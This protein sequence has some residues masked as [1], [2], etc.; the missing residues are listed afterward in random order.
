MIVRER[1]NEFIMIEQHNHALTSGDIMS[2]WKDSLFHG[3]A[4]RKS[5]ETAIYMHDYGWKEFDKQPFWNDQT[6]APYTFSDF[7]T[8]P[9]IILY[10]HGIN[11]VEK[12]DMYAALLCSEHYTRF[13]LNH[14][15]VEAQ[16]FVTEEKK[17]Q[18][19]ILKSLGNIDK[20][21]F[22][23]HYGL[24]QLGDNLSLFLCLN[25]PGV[26]KEKE[27][28]FFKHGIPLASSIEGVNQST[29]G[30]EWIDNQTV[31]VHEFPFDQAFTVAFN[32]K[33]VSKAS[34]KELG[35]I[36]AYEEASSEKVTVQLVPE[37]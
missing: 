6:Q 12:K 11:E 19:R 10:A 2:H 18:K 22:R 7:P 3:K 16:S 5:V 24:L 36:N 32:Q 34:I 29:L 28:H 30:V 27:H 1:E 35:L 8:Y 13:L 21:L 33:K 14:T 17:R 4:N 26:A 20:L 37:P 31:S 25:E 15:S 23:F 9:K